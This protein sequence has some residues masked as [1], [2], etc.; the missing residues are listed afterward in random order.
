MG[1]QDHAGQWALC[2]KDKGVHEMSG[3]GFVETLLTDLVY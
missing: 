2:Y 3:S 1:E